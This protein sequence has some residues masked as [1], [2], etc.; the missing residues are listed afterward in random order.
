MKKF[1]SILLGCLMGAAAFAQTAEEI[2]TR[3]DEVM[4][5][6]K[7]QG[8][9]MTMDMKIPLLGTISTTAYVLGDKMRAE[10]DV[11]GNKLITWQDNTTSWTYDVE[12]NEVEIENKANSSSDAEDNAKMLDGITDGY[13]VS[14]KRQTADAWYIT[15]K[16]LRTN[17]SKDDPKTMDLVVAKGSY[18]PVSLSATVSLVTV[19]LRN[20][21]FGVTE[22]QVTF[23]PANYPGV[24]IVDK[25]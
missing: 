19:T 2:V 4:E 25:R 23:N 14:I 6:D 21:A 17:T 20:F 1:F 22:S 11:S 3:M 10:A 16:K 13:S 8:M 9:T 5:Q 18:M 24:L 7:N 12:K 15:C